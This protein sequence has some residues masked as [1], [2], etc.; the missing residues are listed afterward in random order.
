MQAA[1]ARDGR[2]S[3]A[4]GAKHAA[5]ASPG[6]KPAGAGWRVRGNLFSAPAQPAALEDGGRH[7]CNRD[8][9][10]ASLLTPGAVQ[11]WGSGDGSASGEQKGAAD[12]QG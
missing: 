4:R 12:G 8:Q 6:G 5:A 7:D 10:H 3:A 2:R 11:V 1:E 9:E